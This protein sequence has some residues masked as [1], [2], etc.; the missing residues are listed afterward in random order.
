MNGHEYQ[1]IGWDA[2]DE[3]RGYGW[4]GSDMQYTMY[5]YLSEGP[6]ELQKSIIYHDWGRLTTFVYN[7]PNGTYR[8]TVSV[9]WQGRSYQHNKIVI[10]G[11]PFINDEP[12]DPYLVRTG[13]VAVNDG[14]LTMEMGVFDEYTMLNYLNVE[15]ITP[16]TPPTVDPHPLPAAILYLLLE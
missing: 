15:P 16:P 13:Y 8:V 9:G 3:Q 4:F 1:K 2:Y 11:V 12:A 10:E 14:T 6:N 7:I 5:R